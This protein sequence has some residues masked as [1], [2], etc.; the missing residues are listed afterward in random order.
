MATGQGQP[1]QKMYSTFAPHELF[2]VPDW[3]G[4]LDQKLTNHAHSVCWEPI[5]K[6]N[7]IHRPGCL[8]MLH[9]VASRVI[10]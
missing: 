2:S 8:H 1:S 3:R 10:S 4:F 9:A 7:G 5:P 6:L